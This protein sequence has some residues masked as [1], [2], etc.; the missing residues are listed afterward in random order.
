[1]NKYT[2]YIGLTDKD[3]RDYYGY[4]KVLKLI[5]DYLSCYTY[6][7]C[8]GRYTFKDSTTVSEPTILITYIGDSLPDNLID[9]LLKFLNQESIG[10]EVQENVNFKCIGL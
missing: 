2:L 8:D 1:M 5:D 4:Y 6:T 10:L 3:T 9:E 7:L